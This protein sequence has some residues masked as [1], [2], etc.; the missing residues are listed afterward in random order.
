MCE[1]ET[2]SVR[3]DSGG[4]ESVFCPGGL[5]ALQLPDQDLPG[6][7][8]RQEAAPALALSTATETREQAAWQVKNTLWAVKNWAGPPG[9]TTHR[10]GPSAVG[11]QVWAVAGKGIVQRVPNRGEDGHVPAGVWVEKG[12]L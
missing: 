10:L 11:Q 9:R 3:E 1:V 5:L 4:E 8:Q 6:V 7:W 12:G 2:R